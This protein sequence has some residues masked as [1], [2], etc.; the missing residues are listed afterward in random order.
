MN[1]SAFKIL[2]S[3]LLAFVVTTSVARGE[4]KEGKKDEAKALS[5][6]SIVGNGW[7]EFFYGSDIGK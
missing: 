1:T 7:G 4:T 3:L 5:G 2:V 6:I